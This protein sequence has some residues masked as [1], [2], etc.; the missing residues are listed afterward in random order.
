MQSP[1]RHTTPM[2]AEDAG[3]GA[4]IDPRCR[5]PGHAG[6]AVASGAA[7]AAAAAC[8]AL[9]PERRI[10]RGAIQS[11]CILAPHGA[12]LTVIQRSHASTDACSLWRGRLRT[13]RTACAAYSHVAGPACNFSTLPVMC[14]SDVQ[15]SFLGRQS[16]MPK[17]GGGASNHGGAGCRSFVFRADDSNS[18]APDS[19]AEPNIAVRATCLGTVITLISS[20]PAPTRLYGRHVSA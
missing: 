14:C 18:M 20:R 1:Q 4:G 9:S 12:L 8:Q 7:N 10:G 17:R 15:A 3:S 2:L 13:S 6:D 16:S 19:D 11:G 5:F